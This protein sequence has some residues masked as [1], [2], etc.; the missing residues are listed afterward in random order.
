MWIEVRV[1]MV[2][3]R[4]WICKVE[5]ATRMAETVSTC[6]VLCHDAHAVLIALVHRS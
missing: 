1:G 2:L 4:M 6:H 5:T 3:R